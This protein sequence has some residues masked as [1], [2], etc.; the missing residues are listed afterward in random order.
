MY[1]TCCCRI[2][3]RP[4]IDNHRSMVSVLKTIKFITDEKQRYDQ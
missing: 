3:K 2:G 4:C 1:F